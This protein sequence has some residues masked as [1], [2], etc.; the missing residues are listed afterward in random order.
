MLYGGDGDDELY[1]SAGNDL[2]EGGSGIDSL[3]GGAGDDD[4]AINP[5]SGQDVIVD[6]QG[7]NNIA[8]GAG[9][10]PDS[11]KLQEV[12]ANDGAYYLDIEYGSSGDRVFIKNGPLGAVSSFG[13]ADGSALSFADWIAQSG[14][15]LSGSGGDGDDIIQGGNAADL[16]LGGA[17]NDEIYGGDGADE[18]LG[19]RATTSSMAMA[20]TMR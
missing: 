11:L 18:L 7:S 10:T 20:A 16:M 8:F 19:G 4:Y 6:T 12:Q 17:G 2:L 13:F 3:F 1:G 5:G 14:L 15:S 9:V